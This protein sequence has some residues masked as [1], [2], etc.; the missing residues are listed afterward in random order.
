MK[1]GAM[2]RLIQ[3]GDGNT[4]VFLLRVLDVAGSESGGGIEVILSFLFGSSS[5]MFDE[6]VVETASGT[7]SEG[8]TR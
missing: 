6:A 7:R 2:G 4:T 1:Q 8:Q 3:I 5:V